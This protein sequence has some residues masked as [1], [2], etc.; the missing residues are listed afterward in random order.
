VQVRGGHGTTRNLG[1]IGRRKDMEKYIIAGYEIYECPKS[2]TENGTYYGKTP[3][4]E[5]VR[6]IVE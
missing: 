1:L 2:P 5:Q 3:I 4:A 6:G